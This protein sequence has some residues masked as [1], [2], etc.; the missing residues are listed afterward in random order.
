[1]KSYPYRRP[2]ADAFSMEEIRLITPSG[3]NFDESRGWEQA[4]TYAAVSTFHR[5]VFDF[6]TLY[7]KGYEELNLR[8]VFDICSY[9]T[10]YRNFVVVPL[11]G[12]QDQEVRFQLDASELGGR[13]VFDVVLVAD[14]PTPSE[15]SS[16]QIRNARLWEG[17]PRKVNK[18]SG[19]DGIR[20]VDSS[21][22]GV[23]WDDI[24]WQ[25]EADFASETSDF[26]SGISVYLNTDLGMDAALRGGKNKVA[27]F[28]LV[29]EIMEVV[30]K[31][32]AEF[33]DDDVL[34]NASFLVGEYP[35]SLIA[36][37]AGYATKGRVSFDKLMATAC[38]PDKSEELR[39]ILKRIAGRSVF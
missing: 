34:S 2:P 7:G 21:F 38:S 39:E 28:Y 32:L 22:R 33:A 37:V 8:L 30:V 25:V 17:P 11:T 20:V 5:G 13:I 24:P 18:T 16:G 3:E 29:L 15:A 10:R 19:F 6:E 12:E 14:L 23:G 26:A 9:D 36:A 27:Q 31:R 35:L 1:M 4:G